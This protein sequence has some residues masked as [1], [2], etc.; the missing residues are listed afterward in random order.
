MQS[1]L[2]V[3]IKKNH[4]AVKNY[5]E[6]FKKNHEA[7]QES[8]RL[9]IERKFSH[10]R[11]LMLDIP[12]H[13]SV[14]EPSGKAGKTETTCVSPAS[15]GIK[16]ETGCYDSEEFK[17]RG[18]IISEKANLPEFHGDLENKLGNKANSSMPFNDA[19]KNAS[20]DHMPYS[21]SATGQEITLISGG[22]YRVQCPELGDFLIRAGATGK[23]RVKAATLIISN[24]EQTIIFPDPAGTL[25]DGAEVEV[26]D[27]LAGTTAVTVLP[28]TDNIPPPPP[29]KKGWLTSLFAAVTPGFLAAME[30]ATFFQVVGSVDELIQISGL[31][32]TAITITG[33]G[34]N[35]IFS[36][37]KTATVQGSLQSVLNNGT[38][39][40]KVNG[41][42]TEGLSQTGSGSIV[43]TGD[44]NGTISN[45]GGGS[46]EVMGLYTGKEEEID[47]A[48]GSVSIGPFN[49]GV[50]MSAYSG[51]GF[52]YSKRTSI[53]SEVKWKD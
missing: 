51:Y 15:G 48:R 36:G 13:A 27:N 53:N 1:A 29:S 24:R 41:S 38:G 10:G 50:R 11:R 5:Q 17:E 49:G 34:G 52:S 37:P 20:G 21:T 43:V 3:A 31:R 16:T 33:N 6:A 42:I 14:K 44:V 7:M 35:L 45:T 23:F 40:V 19:N 22:I 26:R 8:L 25:I 18:T 30:E 46:I 12:A 47:N 28:D 9:D 32:P 39:S 4:E 2:E